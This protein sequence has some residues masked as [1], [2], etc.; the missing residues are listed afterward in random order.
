[1]TWLAVDPA[2]RNFGWVLQDEDSIYAA[3]VIRTEKDKDKKTLISEDNVRCALHISNRLE[4]IA[5]RHTRDHGYQ[6]RLVHAESQV[7]SKSSK[8]AQLQGMAWGVICGKFS[9]GWTIHQMQPQTVKKIICGKRTAS[10]E[11]VEDAICLRYPGLRELALAAVGRAKSKAEHIYDAAAIGL[12][13]HLR[14]TGAT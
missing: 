5:I 3:G 10:K 9:N 13:I 1:M 12:A 14:E 11:E 7:G 2:F 8:A 6:A 4:E